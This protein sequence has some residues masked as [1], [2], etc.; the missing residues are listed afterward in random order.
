MNYHYHPFENKLKSNQFK[1]YQYDYMLGMED[2]IY[3]SMIQNSDLLNDAKKKFTIFDNTGLAADLELE[4]YSNLDNELLDQLNVELSFHCSNIFH[5][6]VK[7]IFLNN[8]DVWLNIQKKGEHNPV[9]QHRGLLSFV[10][11]PD[12]PEKI[13]QEYKTQYGTSASR[14]LLEFFSNRSSDSMRFN[15]KTGDIF[16]FSSD[17]RHQVYPFYSDELRFSLAGNIN[18]IEFQN[19]DAI[20][21][22]K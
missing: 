16:L 4:Y 11:Y 15:P 21:Y 5:R 20:T 10:F 22:E 3:V 6:P 9:H 2:K 14:G 19:G 12:I 17:H 8:N 7:N 13:R 18:K 1:I